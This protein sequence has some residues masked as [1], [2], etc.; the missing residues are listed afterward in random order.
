MHLSGVLDYLSGERF[1][2]L[3]CPGCGLVMTHPAPSDLDRYYPPRYRTERQK[4][5]G[6]WRVE[7]R[8]AMLERHFPRMFRGRLLDWGCGT[9]AF[10]VEMQRRG[11]TVAVTELNDAV[12]EQMRSRGIDAKR[13]DEALRDGFSGGAFDAITAW[14]VLEH[15][16]QPLTLAKWA[17]EH[18]FARGIVQ[19]TVP[20]LDSL[21]AR[22]F[23]QHWLH[24]DVPRHLFHFTPATLRALVERAGLREVGLGTVAIEYDLF[25]VIQSLLNV[26][27]HRPNVLFER[28]TAREMPP[29]TRRFDLVTS[30]AMLPFFGTFGL[31][32]CALAGLIGRG[33]TLTIT[34]KPLTGE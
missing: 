31:A 1:D 20:N 23:G 2:L 14:H 3:K 28:L 29:G 13:P 12:L 25:G 11:W 30:W 22:L 19:A 8:R 26:L 34:C 17:A 5:T 15:V 32:H 24:L 6:S 16:P 21:Q 4:Q 27:C 33:G 18:L 7:R 9:G 10:A